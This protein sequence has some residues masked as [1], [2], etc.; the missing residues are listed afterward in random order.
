MSLLKKPS[1]RGGLVLAVGFL[2]AAV[3]LSGCKP[4]GSGS[5]TVG[6]RSRWRET[7]KAAGKEPSAKSRRSESQSAPAPFKSLKDQVRENAK[8]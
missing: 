7:P 4:E 3:G 2:N 8:K 1:L 5:I 6:D